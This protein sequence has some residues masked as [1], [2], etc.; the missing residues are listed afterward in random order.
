MSQIMLYFVHSTLV[1]F[2]YIDVVLTLSIC[3]WYCIMTVSDKYTMT[4]CLLW[5]VVS[6]NM[7][8]VTWYIWYIYIY[9]YM[10]ELVATCLGSSVF[11]HQQV[12]SRQTYWWYY[13]HKTAGDALLFF[14]N[15]F[16]FST[17]IVRI[18]VLLKS[19]LSSTRPLPETML[20]SH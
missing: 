13:A 12:M 20:T 9:I 1:L 18:S 6:S 16:R 7:V 5:K 2:F 3:N 15:R 11:L 8:T 19:R 4:H 14:F 10:G 17:F